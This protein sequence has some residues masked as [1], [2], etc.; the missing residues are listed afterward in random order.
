LKYILI[1]FSGVL[2]ECETETARKPEI[3]SSE[4]VKRQKVLKYGDVDKTNKEILMF[5][6]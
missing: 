5:T 2:W 1:G 6:K 3:W 4:P